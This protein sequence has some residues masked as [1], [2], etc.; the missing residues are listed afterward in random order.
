[1][2][3]D[4]ST[5]KERGINVTLSTIT[6]LLAIIPAA[7][8]VGKPLLVGSI[9]EAI[10]DDVE[11]EVEEQIAPVQTAFKVIILNDI[12]LLKKNIA[13]Y[14]FEEEHEPDSWTE[15]DAR[16]LAEA[17]ITLAAFEEAYREL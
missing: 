7:W 8:F 3:T 6:A 2:G 14:E 10:A 9:S 11:T 4:M 13:Q 5:V 1:M 12:N 16:K 15:E 17:K